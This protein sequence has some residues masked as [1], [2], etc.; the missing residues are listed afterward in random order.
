MALIEIERPKAAHAVMEDV[1]D[2]IARRAQSGS[3]G[4]CPVELTDA[5]V[6]LSASQ[7]CGKCVPCR[8]GLAQMR[9]LVEASSMAARTSA[10]STC[11]SARRATPT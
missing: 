7:S 11:S 2:T 1:C 9:N 4:T 10:T 5:F 3:V 8:V 6:S